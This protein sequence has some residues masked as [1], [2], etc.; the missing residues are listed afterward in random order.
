MALP[1][2]PMPGTEPEAVVLIHGTRTSHSQWDPQVPGLRA[3][4]YRVLAPDLPGHGVRRD[5]PFTLEGAVHV[6]QEAVRDAAGGGEADPEDGMT[7]PGT[8]HLVGSS[9]GGFLAIH[10]AALDATHLASLTA[11][12]ASVQPTPR[13]AG[14]YGRAIGLTDLLPG[15]RSG[16][17]RIFRLLLGEDG[18]RAYL[19]GGRADARVV[20]P[21]M[22]AL[23]GLDLAADLRR[24][25]VPFTVLNGRFDQM[26]LHETRFARSAPRG[27]LEVLPYG[28]HLVN[29]ASPERFTT[30]LLRILARASAL[31]GR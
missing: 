5:Q 10:A 30:D 27:H 28:T 2:V 4:G 7:S 25:P 13:T 24:V 1:V 20:A 11:C 12:G 8:V 29:L 18:A 31:S 16:S 19:R 15:G 26:R 6:I 21:A 23:G 3:A 9:L 22:R 17:S 14:L